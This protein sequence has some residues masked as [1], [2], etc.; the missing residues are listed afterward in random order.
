[1]IFASDLKKGARLV[2]DGDPYVVLVAQTQTPSARGAASLVKVK[3][4]NLRTDQVLDKSYKTD[5]RFDE[6][7]LERKPFQF[8]YEDGEQYVF[9]DQASYDQLYV[10]RDELGDAA[11]YLVD[12]LELK[13][14]FYNGKLLDVELPMTIELEVDTVEPVTRG[15]TARGTVLKPATLTNGMRVMVPQYIKD[16]DRIRVSTKD[17]S[18]AERA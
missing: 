10:T 18:F 8:L 5:E 9:M 12:N 4:R 3:V 14:I 6:P 16:G 15:D 17:G 1:M 7:D 2:V 11:Q 13:L